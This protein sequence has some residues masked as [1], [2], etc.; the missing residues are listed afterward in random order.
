MKTFSFFRVV[1]FL[2]LF[3][4]VNLNAGDTSFINVSEFFPLRVGNVW[5]YSWIYYGNPSA[6]GWVNA[7]VTRDSLINSRKYYLCNFPFLSQWLRIDSA[8]GNIYAY[9]PNGG[10]SYHQGE[11][12]IDSLLSNKG[13]TTSFCSYERRVCTDTGNVQLFGQSFQKRNFG[14]LHVLT[15]SG[16]NYARNIGLHYFSVGDPFQTVYTLRG[17][18]I[19]GILYGDTTLTS[20]LQTGNSLPLNSFLSQNYPNPFNPVTRIEYAVKDEGPVKITLYDII[21]RVIVVLVNEHKLPGNYS[22]EF[23]ASDYNISSGIYLYKFE[24][25][26]F[27][28]TKRMILVK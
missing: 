10:C 20:V 24:A 18:Y 7:Y 5:S 14:P 17:C 6:G 15:A 22:T 11:V 28:E 1:I 21:G 19:N 12:L 13:D 3:Q 27:T 8:S 4:A 2:I 25:S 23:N 26:N 9:S 16:R